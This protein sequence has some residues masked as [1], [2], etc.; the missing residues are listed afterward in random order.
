MYPHKYT[1]DAYKTQI[2]REGAPMKPISQMT[3][4]RL[5]RPSVDWAVL[6]SLGSLALWG[7]A[8]SILGAHARAAGFPQSSGP[9]CPTAPR[10]PLP[11]L[12]A[13][14]AWAH[15]VVSVFLQEVA[16]HVAG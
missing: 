12:P 15:L 1:T 9:V 5:G 8:V 11:F 10:P 6:G 14:Q 3:Y 2:S 4:L 16:G 13:R 7:S